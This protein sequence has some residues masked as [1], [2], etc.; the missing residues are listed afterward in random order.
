MLHNEKVHNLLQVGTLNQQR[1]AAYDTKNCLQIIVV[2]P[3]DIRLLEK[4][5]LRWE[6]D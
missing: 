4:Y 3:L 2:Y 5:M 6:D 1:L